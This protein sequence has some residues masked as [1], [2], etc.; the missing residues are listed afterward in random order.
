[1]GCL[2]LGKGKA[3]DTNTFVSDRAIERLRRLACAATTGSERTILL[4]LMAEEEDH[5]FERET[6]RDDFD[7]FRSSLKVSSVSYPYG[8]RTKLI[9]RYIYVRLSCKVLWRGAPHR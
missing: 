3:M 6:A 8:P 7:L 5:A 2:N 1:M 4:G 9:G